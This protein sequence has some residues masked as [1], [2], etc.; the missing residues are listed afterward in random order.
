MIKRRSNTPTNRV[1][2][3]N[4]RFPLRAHQ[5]RWRTAAREEEEEEQ[6]ER[7]KERDTAYKPRGS[8]QFSHFLRAKKKSSPFVAAALAPKKGVA[9][10]NFNS[11]YSGNNGW[12]DKAMVLVVVVQEK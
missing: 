9:R 2:F 10:E 5:R 4:F 8:P 7:K 12:M 3:R 11:L 1:E 6:Q